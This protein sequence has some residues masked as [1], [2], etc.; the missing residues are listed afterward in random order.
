MARRGLNIPP[1]VKLI[2]NNLA[3]NTRETAGAGVGRYEAMWG[4]GG[5][6]W[7]GWIRPQLDYLVGDLGC[8]VIRSLGCHWGL[9]QGRIDLTTVLTRYVQVASYL[10]DMGAYFYP[11]GDSHRDPVWTDGGEGTRPIGETAPMHIA[12]L[13]ELHQVGNIIGYDILNEVDANG[14]GYRMQP[15][16]CRDLVAAIKDAGVAVPLTFSVNGPFLTSGNSFINAAATFADLDFLDVHDYTYAKNLNFYADK[17]W[18]ILVGETGVNNASG[19]PE[20]DKGGPHSTQ[21]TR[22]LDV[23][24]LMQRQ[25]AVR[26]ILHWAMGDQ[27]TTQAFGVY[28]TNTSGRLDQ[29]IDRPWLTRIIKAHTRGSVKYTNSL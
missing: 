29:F 6:N 16:Y 8:N 22:M 25:P 19:A 27:E 28:N 26:G 24:S 21:V 3:L 23:Y 17:G 11:N 7:D 4:L 5:F 14:G 13:N 2:G 12:V 10:K 18:D 15:N 20:N 1:G 9:V